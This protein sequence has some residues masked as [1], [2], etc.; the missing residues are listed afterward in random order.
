MAA[1]IPIGDRRLGGQCPGLKG[2]FGEQ[3]LVLSRLW[4][5]LLLDLVPFA[6]DRQCR[7]PV[8]T[9]DIV[10]EAKTTVVAYSD[11][12]IG[13]VDGDWM[14]ELDLLVCVVCELKADLLRAP[15]TPDPHDEISK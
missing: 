11:G 13:D 5:Q 7:A 3:G 9:I 14:I 10:E 4:R 6:R 2:G 1:R 15:S 12:E 8:M